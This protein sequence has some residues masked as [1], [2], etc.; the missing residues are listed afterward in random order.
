MNPKITYKINLSFNLGNA[1]DSIGRLEESF[2][3]ISSQYG[4]DVGLKI[5]GQGLIM[6]LTVSRELKTKEREMIKKILLE[7]MNKH[8]P[9]W[10]FRVDSMRRKSSKSHSQSESR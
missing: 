7:Q 10:E 4:V 8:F 5:R 3:A 1:V 2:D 6:N 9:D